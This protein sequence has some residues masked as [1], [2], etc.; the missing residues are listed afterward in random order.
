MSM[1]NES[2]CILWW[3]PDK[4][5]KNFSCSLAFDKIAEQGLSV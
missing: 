3:I 5:D 2:V 4:G 1:L